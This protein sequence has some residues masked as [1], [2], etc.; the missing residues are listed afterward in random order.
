MVHFNED[1]DT[2]VESSCC[3]K[4]TETT[5][6][7]DPWSASLAGRPTRLIAPKID[8]DLIEMLKKK[9]IFFCTYFLQDM[10]QKIMNDDPAFPLIPLLR[11][12]GRCVHVALHAG[13][14]RAAQS[15][16]GPRGGQAEGGPIH[17]PCR[18]LR[19]HRRRHV[20]H[21]LRSTGLAR[22]NVASRGALPSVLT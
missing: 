2:H 15:V 3:L 11:R 9:F 5:R 16:R 19:D 17:E 14:A 1:N 13:P 22:S 10:H 6:E 4:D 21:Q 7:Y 20:C 18:D 8:V 12:Q